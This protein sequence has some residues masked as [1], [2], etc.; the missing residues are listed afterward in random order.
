[1]F[2]K[3]NIWKKLCIKNN[4]EFY[5]NHWYTSKA[6]VVDTLLCYSYWDYS[7]LILNVINELHFEE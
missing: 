7:D 2:M 5:G 3:K 1:M 4:A 6:W